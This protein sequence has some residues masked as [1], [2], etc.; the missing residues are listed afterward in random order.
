MHGW[1][2][3]PDY[4]G[5]TGLQW[6]HSVQGIPR[7][8]RGSRGP[9]VGPRGPICWAMDSNQ[10]HRVGL[11]RAPGSSLNQGAEFKIKPGPMGPHGAQKSVFENLLGLG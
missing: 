6:L 8:P 5:C 2:H 4:S 11:A 9:E 3:A 1:C 10:G 7:A